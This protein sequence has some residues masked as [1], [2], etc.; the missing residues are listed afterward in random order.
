M[1]FD[2]GFLNFGHGVRPVLE[3]TAKASL[4]VALRCFCRCRTFVGTWKNLLRYNRLRSSLNDTIT[5]PDA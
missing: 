5:L 3:S 2:P 1:Y 4:T